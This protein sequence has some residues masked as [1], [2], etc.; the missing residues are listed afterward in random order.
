[1]KE[2]MKTAGRVRPEAPTRAFKDAKAWESWLAK[3]HDAADGVWMRMA[4][5]ASGIKSEN[6]ETIH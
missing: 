2:T 1:M 4:K 3:N 6:G 5:K